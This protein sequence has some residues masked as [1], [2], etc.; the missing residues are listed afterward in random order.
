MW[1]LVLSVSG[2]REVS[3]GTLEC[4]VWR[5]ATIASSTLPGED[6]NATSPHQFPLHP[7]E[8]SSTWPLRIPVLYLRQLRCIGCHLKQM[9]VCVCVG[10]LLRPCL[11]SQQIDVYHKTD[12]VDSITDQRRTYVSEFQRKSSRQKRHWL[13]VNTNEA[14][15]T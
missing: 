1:R 14:L 3:H 6:S 8:R 11:E 15:I 5:T 2:E 12:C 4:F 7:L 13:H 9:C 10:W